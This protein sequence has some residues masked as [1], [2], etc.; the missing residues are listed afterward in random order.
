MK[1]LEKADRIRKRI[2]EI[3]ILR[4]IAVIFMIFDHIMYDFG[5]MM[6]SLFSDYPG[7]WQ[8]V[9]E[10]AKLYWNWGV[11]IWVRQLI[12][13]IFL[14]LTGISCSFSKNNLL[15]GV[16]LLAVALCITLVTYIAGMILGT[17]DLTISFGVLHCISLALLLIGVLE[18]I[19]KRFSWGK[20]VYLGIGCIMIG[21]GAYFVSM[22]EPVSYVGHSLTKI[23]IGQILGTVGAG[24]DSFPFLLYG[25]EVFV[26]VFLGKLLYPNRASLFHAHYRNNFLTA[27]GRHSLIV[28]ILHQVIVTVL[29]A[30]ILLLCGF[31]LSF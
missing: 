27:I 8:P 23:M 2:I 22:R 6:E 19:F 15:R 9:M 13:F 14:G 1:Q 17:P 18:L 5:F 21:A 31:H 16:K 29:M 30:L 10:F 26:G 3:D 24:S 25:G 11:R 20:W 4:G 12:L 7:K 28:Y